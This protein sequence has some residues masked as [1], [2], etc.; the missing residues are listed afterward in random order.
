MYSITYIPT[1]H[2]HR[3][4]RFC[5]DFHTHPQPHPHCYSMLVVHWLVASILTLQGRH[6][7]HMQESS[8]IWKSLTV[9]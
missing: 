9:Q 2:G 5:V 8:S 7:V 3:F 1:G 6:A 4:S